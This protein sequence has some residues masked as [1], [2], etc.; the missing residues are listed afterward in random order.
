[1]MTSEPLHGL[2]LTESQT[3]Y[4]YGTATMLPMVRIDYLK[5]VAGEI[6]IDPYEAAEH[7]IRLSND[8]FKEANN[9]HK[10]NP[11]EDAFILFYR[12]L[13]IFTRFRFHPKYAG[14]SEYV[15]EDIVQKCLEAEKRLK[16][17]EELLLRKFSDE[18]KNAMVRNEL[19]LLTMSTTL[20]SA[21]GGSSLQTGS[22]PLQAENVETRT[23][24]VTRSLHEPH[25]ELNPQNQPEPQQ[26][27]NPQQ[28]MGHQYLNPQ[29]QSAPEQEQNLQ[30][31]LELQ[32][33]NSQNQ[34]E[35]KNEQNLQEYLELQELN[36]QNQ[37]EPKQEQ[38]LPEELESQQELNHQQ[39]YIG[40]GR[41]K[42]CVRR[43]KKPKVEI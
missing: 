10:I 1:M 15:K 21:T 24:M 40:E 23:G 9:Y 3:A 18:H 19:S 34:P 33:L 39:L 28:H 20:K 13:S 41:G 17:L 11:A 6:P 29:K 26:E 4:K 2:H 42:L 38:N 43:K 30:E 32:L 5:Q 31:Y 14:I 12:F 16:V 7:Y 37:P 25:P 22:L 27:Q 36:F 8:L 35:P